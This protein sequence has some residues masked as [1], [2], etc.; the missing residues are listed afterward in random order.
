MLA[1]AG[2]RS[3]DEALADFQ[4]KVNS[5]K[6]ADVTV[7]CPKNIILPPNTTY[8]SHVEID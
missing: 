3:I 7:L 6:N 2:F 8:N 1:S 4:R 5:I